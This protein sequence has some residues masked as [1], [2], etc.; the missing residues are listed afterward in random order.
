MIS[1]LASI[2]WCFQRVSNFLRNTDLEVED[3]FSD[4]FLF[5]LF[6]YKVSVIRSGLGCEVLKLL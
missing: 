1:V 5:L 2:S 3:A 6:F 4:A